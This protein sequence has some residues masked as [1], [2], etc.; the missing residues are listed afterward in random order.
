[1]FTVVSNLSEAQRER[2]TSSLSV[3]GM[4][5]TVCTFEAVRTVFVEL[6]CTPKSSM[7]NS[8]LHVS[9]HGSSMNRTFIVEDCAED[10][11]GQWGTD[12]VTGEQGHIDGG[13][14]FSWTWDDNGYAWQS[15]PV[16]G[17]HVKRREGQG[18]EKRTGR[19]FFGDEQA[20]DPEWWSKEDFAWSKGM[21]GKKGLSK[22]N[23]G[24]QKCGFRPYQPDKGAGKD[25]TQ[26]KGKGKRN[27]GRTKKST[28]TME[29]REM[30]LKKLQLVID[31]QSPMRI[32]PDSL[33]FLVKR[34][35]QDHYVLLNRRQMLREWH[36]TR[37]MFH[38]E[39]GVQSVLRVVDE[40][41]RTD[42]LW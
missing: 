2:L 9:G 17:R 39:I 3:Q 19:A 36:T 27:K 41:L 5:V 15:R 10:D 25:Y 31:E 21:K 29:T 37:H 13:R 33:I 11:F 42:E 22:G 30:R 28:T 32:K 4:N 6:F 1:M 14:S 8:S 35:L 20:Q 18:K 7:E 12:E 23:D 34:K 26:N 24:F 38:S 40:V 16:K